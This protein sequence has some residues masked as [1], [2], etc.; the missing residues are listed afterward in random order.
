MVCISLTERELNDVGT[1]NQTYHGVDPEE[2]VDRSTRV[3]A[4]DG[5]RVIAT[6]IRPTEIT[7]WLAWETDHSTEGEETSYVLHMAEITSLNDWDGGPA[8]YGPQ[9][10][11]AAIEC[12]R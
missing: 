12:V 1:M 4:G 7:A 2:S 3:D 11:D 10:L 6:R 8:P 9:A 5:Y